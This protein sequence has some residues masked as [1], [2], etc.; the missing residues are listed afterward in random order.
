MKLQR[1]ILITLGVGLLII[2]IFFLITQNITKY[3]GFFI[4]EDEK[5]TDFQSCLTKQDIILYVNTNDVST[6]Q[7]IE[8]FDYLQYF[9]IMNCLRNNQFCLDNGV[10]SFPTWIINNQKINNDINFQQLKE[11]SSCVEEIKE[12]K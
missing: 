4:S 11:L 7:N 1:R 12:I 5:E 2:L 6:L 3:T 10:D 8:L 9:G